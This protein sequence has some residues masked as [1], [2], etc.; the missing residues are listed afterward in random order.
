MKTYRLYTKYHFYNKI[1]KV[2]IRKGDFTMNDN[3]IR[4]FFN[5]HAREWDNHMEDASSKINR[6]LDGI[7]PIEGM[8][9]LDVG[10]GTGVLV[11]YLI[12]RH[13][14][15]ITECDISNKMIEVNRSKYAER[16]DVSHIVGDASHLEFNN[17]YDRI[18]IYNAFPHFSDR[19][20]LIS[21]LGSNLRKGG[22]I[23]IAHSRTSAELDEHHH[24]IS[25]AIYSHLG[26][27]EKIADLLKDD[28]TDIVF[29]DEPFF[30]VRG[31]KA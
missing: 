8:S 26:K 16:N 28:F 31:K 1:Q 7:E 25:T 15:H 23:V 20:R 10:A 24:N 5:G 13:A 14:G 17:R 9:I 21:N 29:Q 11:P 30:M 27:A 22:Y 2:D 19:P 18:I 12:E 4:E 3:Q 6:I